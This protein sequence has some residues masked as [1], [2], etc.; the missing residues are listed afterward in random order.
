MKEMKEIR[1][2]ITDI[3]QGWDGED[4]DD[5]WDELNSV[6]SRHLSGWNYTISIWDVG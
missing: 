6:M 2:L 3:P 1:I 5:L 4:R